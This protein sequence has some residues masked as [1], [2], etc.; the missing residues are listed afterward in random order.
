MIIV[1]LNSSQEDTVS[2]W[3]FDNADTHLK[4]GKMVRLRTISIAIVLISVAQIL[5]GCAGFTKYGELEKNARQHYQ[6]GDYDLAVFGC[7]ESLILN[8]QYN[9]AQTLIKDTFRISVNAH[10]ANIEELK[11]SWAK[12]KWDNIVAEYKALIKLKRAVES[13][14][15]LKVRRT[16]EIIR[17]ELTGYSQNL[18]EAEANAADVHYQ[19]GIHL[20][21]KEGMDLKKQA[22]KEFKTALHFVP[23]YKDASYRYEECRREA[24]K[25]MVIIPFEDKTGKEGKYGAISEMITD[26]IIASVM[27]DPIATEFL[28]LVSREELGRVLREQEL[29]MSGWVDE[30][31]V[32]EVGELLGVHEILFGKITQITYI[33]PE[34]PIKRLKRKT[35]VVVR[36]VKH[37]DAEGGTTTKK[38]YRTVSAKVKIYTRK[39]KASIIGSYKIVEVKTAKLRKSASLRGET[40]FQY[41][42]ATYDGDKRA[43]EN[44]DKELI[45][46]GKKL[47]P[48][49][50]ELVLQAARN[51]SASLAEDLKAYVR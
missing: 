4:G 40:S 5:T 35:D 11:A 32:V 50:E 43:L 41:Q 23:D 3:K 42:W 39:T 1:L 13:L 17:F 47:A 46:K 15:T 45:A 51:L 14:P 16:G 8:P 28:E 25:R 49:E 20:S 34:T 26:E 24:I 2:S 48:P 36:E 9:K 29:Q 30:Q 18:M 7:V 6:S 22:A 31:S 12:F 19:A 27:G 33:P 38:V 21:H 37:K 10:Q 44:E